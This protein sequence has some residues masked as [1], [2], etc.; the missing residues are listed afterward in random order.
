MYQQF[1]DIVPAQY[2]GKEIEVESAIKLKNS[3]EAKIFYELVKNRLL[4]VNYWHNLAGLFSAVFSLVDANGIE[5]DRL[6]D[7]GDF[8]KIDVPG[9]GSSD[10][11]GF[12]WVRI[13]EKKEIDEENLQFTGFTVR[14][15]ANPRGNK[16]TIAHFYSAEATSSF[17][18]VRTDNEIKAMIFDR[19]LKANNVAGTA[20]DKLRDTAVG[21]SAIGSFSKMQW[22][23]LAN[24]LIKQH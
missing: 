2:T 4:D 21:I 6:A 15:C 12:D 17:M 5:V 13:E 16:K 18:A 9:P 19:N 8:I 23:N 1:L 10:G 11:D 14:P 22:Q 20:T 7:N 24:G 3:D